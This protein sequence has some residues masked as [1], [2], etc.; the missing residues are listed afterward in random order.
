[1][2]V[3]LSIDELVLLDVDPRHGYRI[4]DAVERE[5]TKRVTASHALALAARGTSL[6]RLHGP[7]V[8]LHPGATWSARA[9]GVSI[10]RSVVGAIERRSVTPRDGSGR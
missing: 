2:R 4:A 3:D 5:L 1:M 9:L 7:A 6:E 10:G 8:D